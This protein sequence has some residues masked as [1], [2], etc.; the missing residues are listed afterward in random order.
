MLKS[1]FHKP[2][3]ASDIIYR[4][5]VV[6][7][8][9]QYAEKSLVLVS[10]P[11]GYG[12]SIMVSQ[13][14]ESQKKRYSWLSLDKSLNNFTV[15]M[16]YFTEAL[17][18]LRPTSTNNFKPLVQASAVLSPESIAEKVC[19]ELFTNQ[20]PEILV[21]D[22]YYLIDNPL[23]HQLI[24]Y[25]L[26]N[27]PPGKQ[28]VII[29]RFDPPL[30]FKQHRLYGKLLEVRIK[31]LIIDSK[32]FEALINL[33]DG[34]IIQEISFLLDLSE[35]WILGLAMLLKFESIDTGNLASK[36]VTNGIMD[37]DFLL[38]EY[39]PMLPEHF[40]RALLL[41]GLCDR[42]NEKLLDGLFRNQLVQDIEAADFISQ[43]K[44]YNLFL[45]EEDHKEN[46]YRFHHLFTEVLRRK[47]NRNDGALLY[48]S[49]WFAGEGYIEEA[50]EYLLRKGDLDGATNLVEI[51][52]QD[53][54]N[55]GEW[56]RLQ[57]WLET[58]PDESIKANPALLL[59]QIWVLENYWDHGQ[60]RDVLFLLEE[61]I[62][63]VGVGE[64]ENSEF[65]FHKSF[66]QLIFN[67]DPAEALKNAEKSKALH[68]DSKM[69][70][71]RRE[72]VIAASR[73][74]RGE[75]DQS[76]RYIEEIGKRHNPGEVMYLRSF[77][78]RVFLLLLSGRF[79]IAEQTT[80][81]F[82]YVSQNTLR[83]MEAWSI[84]LAANI[85]F[86]FFDPHQCLESLKVALE[87]EGTMD[88][89]AYVD[90]Y[91]GTALCRLLLNDIEGANES[92]RDMEMKLKQMRGGLFLHIYTGVKM[93]IHWL[94]GEQ[95]KALSWAINKM[96]LDIG[97]VDPLFMMEVPELTRI[98][99]LITYGSNK[100]LECG[101]N[102]LES[103]EDAV[104]SVHN[105]YHNIDI[106]LLKALACYRL[107]DGAQSQNFISMSFQV[108]KNQKIIRP[109]REI[110]KVAPDLFSQ[111][112][113]IP[114]EIMPKLSS[115]PKPGKEKKVASEIKANGVANLTQR[116]LQIVGLTTNGLQNKE[117]AN[118][119]NISI[120]TVKSH[121]AH[122]YQKLDVHNRTSMVRKMQ[123]SNLDSP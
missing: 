115:P 31:D 42:F 72:M 69:L 32:E 7:K 77:S 82:I 48:I 47:Q 107:G 29:S 68:E 30:K 93:R 75:I 34:K 96:I 6:N 86:Q 78:T 104:K 64:L 20:D 28:L 110:N 66:H 84:Y 16:D 108:Y 43:L 23:I 71:A 97:A 37:L 18:N 100:E 63:E 1:R 120:A 62:N 92:L 83:Y 119:L 114:L 11:A 56:W 60:I 89:R 13:W 51:H 101:M 85:D 113:N 49:N 98:R 17:S 14:L 2:P 109:F 67:S 91:A 112:E 25:L 99:I 39:L 40:S 9:N 52:R 103:F 102:M 59:A 44:K 74:M 105:S 118:E 22:D 80:R 12:K 54:F 15:F 38:G 3:I 10:A 45:I 55:R 106:L 123:K 111:T 5:R 121:L 27:C 8:L 4:E 65:L 117:I 81:R 61:L 19:N 94:Q 73:Q 58:L 70:G 90:A 76:I 79:P 122:I 95:K 50:I 36:I 88:W 26:K 41:A 46:W 116:E 21:F 57:S 33:N 87:Y 35:G 53:V 24:N